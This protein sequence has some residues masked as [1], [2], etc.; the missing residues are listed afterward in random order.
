MKLVLLS[1]GSGTRLWPLSNE[2][3]PKQFIEIIPNPRGGYESMFQ[4]VM[5]QIKECDLI[6]DTFIATTQQHTDL[7][8]DQLIE[9]IPLIVEPCS[10]D[11]FPAISLS[12]VYLYDKIGC[13][14]DEV[15][16]VSPVDVY[17]E[18]S[19]FQTLKEAEDIL[20]KHDY[21]LALVGIKPSYPA[22]KYGYILPKIE[23]DA[24]IMKVSKFIE[25]PEKAEAM[26][27][28]EQGA[29]WNCGVF[30]FKLGFLINLLEEK[31]IPLVY[32]ELEREF[33]QLPKISFDY[34]V[35]EKIASIV[36]IPY[37]GDWDDLGTWDILTSKL[38]KF[39]FG[40]SYLGENCVNTHIINYLDTPILGVGLTDM[41]I[42]ANESGI[43]ISN[44]LS[45]NQLKQFINII[46]EN[47]V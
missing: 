10:R 9:D 44:K 16:C 2:A 8:N 13:D 29:L 3:K 45:S 19:Y 38:E 4:R 24:S 22:E 27:L 21:N 46:K 40:K 42:V 1:G 23:N 7:I 36:V 6:R 18:A 39:K 15:V 32:E 33:T 30:C 11:T 28:L 35:V 14:F 41:V 26:K 5:E 31:G 47:E 25:K 34:E 37:Q 12:A 43:L 20:K 17:A